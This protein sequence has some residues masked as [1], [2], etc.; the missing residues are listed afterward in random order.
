MAL[1]RIP[2]LAAVALCASAA[3]APGHAV[4]G[5]PDDWQLS[6]SWRF[7]AGINGFL[8]DVGI[9]T[10]LPD[11]TGS[12]VNLGIK[13]I[14]DHLKMAF[15]GVVEAQKG[16]WGGF[17]DVLYIDLG[18]APSSTHDF[19]LRPG[20]LPAD[21][22]AHITIDVK[23][24]IWTLAGS[25]RAIANPR[26]IIDVFAGGRLF[27]VSTHQAWRLTG[28]V[29][30]IPLP[31]Q[32]GSGAARSSQWDAIIGGKGRFALGANREWFVPAYL[33][34]GT[35]GSELTWQALGGIGHAFDWGEVTA[36]WRYLYYREGAGSPI[37]DQDMSGPQLAFVYRW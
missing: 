24:T 8:P 14:L 28:N 31:E 18:A 15:A 23:A 25:Y 7:G 26:S 35:G 19:S 32:S 6:D 12:D 20:P 36:T 21:V 4:A 2:L 17:T 1:T 11:G 27:D 16:R 37:E 5:T 34:V 9:K 3:A 29:G 22:T 10:T 33:D 13:T 30:S